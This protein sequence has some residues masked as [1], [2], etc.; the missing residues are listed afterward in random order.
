[1]IGVELITPTGAPNGPALDQLQKECFNRGLLLLDC[2][3]EDHVIRFLPP[4][5]VSESELN[6]ALT[7]FEQ[8]LSTVTLG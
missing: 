5:N 6:E 7:I 2:G 1:M 8:S 3:R 4:L